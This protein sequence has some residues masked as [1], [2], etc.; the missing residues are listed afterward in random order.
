M[1]NSHRRRIRHPAR[2]AVTR[3]SFGAPLGD[4]FAAMFGAAPAL[5]AS[6]LL[7]VGCSGT[8]TATP[9]EAIGNNAVFLSED[10]DVDDFVSRFESEDR[11]VAW[12]RDEIVAA[13]GIRPGEVV[14]DV[15]AGTGLF[16]P[17]LCEAVGPEGEV[18]A[19]EISPGFV[20]HLDARIADEGLGNARTVQC[21]AR[22]SNLAPDSVD[23]IFVC[24]TYHHFDHPADTL[25]SLHA[26]LRDGGRLVIVEFHRKP[27]ISNDWVLDHMRAGQETFVREITAAGF[28]LARDVFI[29]RLRMNYMLIFEK[30]RG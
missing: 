5:A 27:G 11:E 30:R 22:S 28:A 21:D 19:V 16:L 9:D 23:L 26:A 17:A 8:G 15:G 1:S 20:A 29:P 12:A 14:A 13:L 18:V 10:H 4:T 7:A 24:D 6:L 25:A 3:A 2:P